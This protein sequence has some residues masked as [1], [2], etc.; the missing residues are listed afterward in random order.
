MVLTLLGRIMITLALLLA[1]SNC[2][3]KPEKSKEP[4]LLSRIPAFN[5]RDM[6]GHEFVQASIRTNA[7]YVQFIKSSDI[8]DIEFFRAAASDIVVNDSGANRIWVV[9]FTD[10]MKV[11]F[12][13]IQE[14]TNLA[15][16]TFIDENFRGFREL[17]GIPECCARYLLFDDVGKLRYSNITLNSYEESL[18]PLLLQVLGKT[19]S[20]DAFLG[21]GKEISDTRFSEIRGYFG[22]AKFKYAIISFHRDICSTCLSGSIISR[23]KKLSESG[24]YFLMTFMKRGIDQNDLGNLK[25]NLKIPFQVHVAS[26]LFS[27]EW[28]NVCRDYGTNALNDFV[29]LIDY[30]GLIRRA[31]YPS[32]R[33]YKEI[34][35]FLQ[36][37]RE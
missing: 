29:L 21:I 24:D 35:D 12:P 23:M 33:C 20:I 4:V 22:N 31:A 11:L 10:D 17:F 36:R 6:Y 9:V 16:F 26:K 27:E 2:E 34:F 13:R 32:C 15:N 28:E 8:N 14:F 7:W 25:R 1:L 18:K 30:K 5:S 37:T 19:F 3:K